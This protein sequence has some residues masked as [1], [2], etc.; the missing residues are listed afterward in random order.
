MLYCGRGYKKG[1]TSE[2]LNRRSCSVNKAPGKDV[3]QEPETDFAT[4]EKCPDG[5]K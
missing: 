4:D 2:G 5:L 1:A 3:L